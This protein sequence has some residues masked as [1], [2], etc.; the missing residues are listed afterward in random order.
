MVF[1]LCGMKVL[2]TNTGNTTP[3]HWKGREEQTGIFKYPE[4]SGITLGLDHV[5]GDTVSDR[6]HHGGEY[7]AC[8]LFASDHY[9]YW[10]ARYPGLKWTWGMFGE[11]V[12]VEGMDE[13]SMLVGSIYR[14]GSALVQITIP[15]EP[16]YKLGIR[17]DDQQIIDEF[18]RYGHPGTY[19][20][21]L[22]PG[23]VD[24]MD[25]FKL[26]EKAA[27]SISIAHLFALLCRK[28]KNQEHLD[29]ALRSTMLPPRTLNKLS[30]YQKKGA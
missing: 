25:E 11:N 27:D 10:K 5:E 3:I 22:E 26:I 24:T 19:V 15:R 18:I 12:T 14:L 9:P 30:R 21:V 4:K 6:R 29:L 8:Y 16:C 7:K 28:Q 17:F 13:S 23:H 2:S 20:R 1:Y